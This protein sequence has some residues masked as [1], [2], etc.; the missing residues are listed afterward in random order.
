MYKTVWIII[1]ESDDGTYKTELNFQH[2]GKNPKFP[3]WYMEE[4]HSYTI[5]KIWT[6]HLIVR[7]SIFFKCLTHQYVIK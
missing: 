1:D 7:P 4:N 5:E 6:F 2:F 3:T